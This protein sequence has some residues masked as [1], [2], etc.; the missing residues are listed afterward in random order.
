MNLFYTTGVKLLHN[1]RF[2]YLNGKFSVIYCV[3]ETGFPQVFP[4]WHLVALSMRV[5]QNFR[6]PEV[7][8]FWPPLRSSLVRIQLTA[9]L[10][11]N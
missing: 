8:R 5:G 6:A 2:I 10:E 4:L 1:L 3:Q 11:G 7:V 9:N